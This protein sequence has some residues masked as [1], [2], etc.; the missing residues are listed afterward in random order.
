MRPF[1]SIAR[2]VRSLNRLHLRLPSFRKSRR[3][4]G[5]IGAINDMR[6]RLPTVRKEIPRHAG[7][8]QVI[9]NLHHFAPGFRWG[10]GKWRPAETLNSFHLWLPR[11]LRRLKRRWKLVLCVALVGGA[12]L[13]FGAHEYRSRK[14]ERLMTQAREELRDGHIRESILAASAVLQREPEHEGACALIASA[15][16]KNWPREALSWFQRAN[17]LQPSDVANSLAWAR[18]ALELKRPGAAREALAT[19]PPAERETAEFHL[20]SAKVEI[21]NADLLKAESDLERAVDISPDNLDFRRELATLRLYF[22]DERRPAA[23]ATLEK[24][25]NDPRTAVPALRTLSRDAASHSDAT[26]VVRYMVRM[27]NTAGVPLDD[28]LESLGFLLR[29]NHPGFDSELRVLEEESA[30]DFESVASMVLWMAENNLALPAI[31]WLA[32]LPA[33]IRDR[34]SV[35][36]ALAQCLVALRDWDR[37]QALV[38]DGDWKELDFLRVALMARA[39]KE[40]GHPVEAANQWALA[41][42]KAEKH[43][44]SLAMLSSMATSWGPAWEGEG[45]NLAWMTFE[46]PDP[47]MWL[48]W[49]MH[50]RYVAKGDSDHLYRLTA[51]LRE[52]EPTDRVAQNNFAMLSLLLKQNETEAQ[53]LARHL[54]EI[55]PG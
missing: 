32:D 54:F 8:I 48:L 1:R 26:D 37:L 18:T 31:E 52:I 35:R 25:A 15:L 51:R 50:N 42:L 43:P 7:P 3:R 19:I 27:K 45:E 21:A 20:L 53:G 2:A 36:L 34:S 55:L 11:L 13:G 39:Q 23:L 28:R 41:R 49:S 9:N 17:H 33:S 14:T 22:E 16:S 44:Q 24:L 4:R 47:P 30:S 10:L 6:F 29:L 12:A 5:V 46:Q 38:A 40:A